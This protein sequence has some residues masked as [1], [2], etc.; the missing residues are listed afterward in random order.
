MTD[1]FRQMEEYIIDPNAPASSI[2]QAITEWKTRHTGR[3]TA[4]IVGSAVKAQL[5]KAEEIFR[6]DI[7]VNPNFDNQTVK[8]GLGF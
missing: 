1:I 7:T 6:M 8:I 3:P 2:R 5:G 4:I